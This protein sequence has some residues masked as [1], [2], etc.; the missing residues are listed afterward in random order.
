VKPAFVMHAAIAAWSGPPRES[1]ATLDAQFFNAASTAPPPPGG[2]PSFEV[3]AAH[4]A[5]EQATSDASMSIRDF[6]M[7]R[8]L[9]AKCRI[10]AMLNRKWGEIWQR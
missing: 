3:E 1:L 10:A 9:Q 4:A 8:L 7:S 2:A 5:D 6:F